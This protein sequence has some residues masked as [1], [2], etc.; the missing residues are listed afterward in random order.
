M[1]KVHYSAYFC[2]LDAKIFELLER[3]HALKMP[4]AAPRAMHFSK[5]ANAFAFKAT[6]LAN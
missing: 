6:R 3:T 4:R 2:Q 1:D 5:L